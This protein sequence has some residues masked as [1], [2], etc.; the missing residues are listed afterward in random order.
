MYFNFMQPPPLRD[1][2]IAYHNSIEKYHLIKIDI[3]YKYFQNRVPL[4]TKLTFSNFLQ[5]S[6]KNFLKMT[7]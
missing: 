3:F 4:P 6:S 7:F 2:N 5:R 1:S